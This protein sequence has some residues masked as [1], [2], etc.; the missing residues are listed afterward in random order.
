[1]N[2][3]F[4]SLRT[5]ALTT[6]FI[7][8]MACV[9]ASTSETEN[10]TETKDLTGF[11]KIS[12]NISGNLYLTQ[13]TV[14]KVDIEAEPTDLAEIITLVEDETLIIKT[15][16][17]WHNLNNV[18]VYVTMPDIEGL[19]VAG[20]GNIIANDQIKTGT[21]ELSIAGSGNI[22]LEKLSAE[23]TNASIAGSGNINVKGNSSESLNAN[24]AGSGN[25]NCNACESKNVKVDIAGS[26]SANVFAT[27]N[28]TTNIVGSGD[29]RYNGR[30]LINANSTGSGSTKPL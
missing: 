13:G 5:I 15:K 7:S 28:L 20:S 1:M 11:K 14:Y 2:K 12:F 27:E 30:P 22:N 18:K 9:S 4:F 24:I 3:Y 8:L 25:V 6:L 16:P 17:G 19:A 29:V 10:Q 26:G 23:N 21:I